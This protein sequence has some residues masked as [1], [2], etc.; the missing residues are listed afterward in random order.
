MSNIIVHAIE[1]SWSFILTKLEEKKDLFLSLS[2]N[3][4]YIKFT[5]WYIYYSSQC[6]YVDTGLLCEKV[7]IFH[8]VGL[9]DREKSY[10]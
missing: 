3:S 8:D 4:N 1:G 2:F 7:P 6:L 10:F 5:L 9:L